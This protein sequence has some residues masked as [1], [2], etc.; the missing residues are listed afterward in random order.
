MVFVVELDGVICILIGLCMMWYVI[1][2]ILLLNV[3]E[4]NSVWCSGD[5]WCSMC[6]KFGIKFIFS[7]W[8]VLLSINILILFKNSDFIWV[9]LSKCFGVVIK[10]FIL[11]CKWLSCIFMFVLL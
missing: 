6:C 11:L 2:L 8:F 5:K 3:V 9:W 7:M 1:V 10:I 4:K